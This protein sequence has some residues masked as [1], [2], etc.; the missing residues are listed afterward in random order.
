MHIDAL[1]HVVMCYLC[2]VLAVGEL[3][4]S[5][6][7]TTSSSATSGAGAMD[8][9]DGGAAAELRTSAAALASNSDK[10]SPGNNR[11]PNKGEYEERE[12]C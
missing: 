4:G 8:A 5:S 2:M 12:V 9:T 10:Q 11:K 3:Y 1:L 6:D 7:M